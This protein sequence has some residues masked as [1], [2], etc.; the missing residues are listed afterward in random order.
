MKAAGWLFAVLGI[1]GLGLSL[2]AGVVGWLD[3]RLAPAHLIPLIAAV[4]FGAL[5]IGGC[6]LIAGAGPEPP[7][8]KKPGEYRGPAA[9]APRTD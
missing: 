2:F 6:A 4:V 5:F 9:W 8:E 7:L 1:L 3:P